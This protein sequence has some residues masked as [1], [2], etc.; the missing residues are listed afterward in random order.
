M[1]ALDRLCSDY[2]LGAHTIDAVG[3]HLYQLLAAET[4]AW[5]EAGYPCEKWPVIGE[6][7]DWQTDPETGALRYLRT[8]QLRTPEVYWYL[9][10]VTGTPHVFDLCRDLYRKPSELLE[11]L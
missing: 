2:D 1:G 11:V 10:A 8:P 4:Q 5:R 9:P 6:I 7:L 3:S